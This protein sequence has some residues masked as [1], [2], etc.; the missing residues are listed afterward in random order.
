ML[1]VEF[2][3]FPTVLQSYRLTVLQSYSLIVLLIKEQ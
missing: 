3:I 2:G 1:K